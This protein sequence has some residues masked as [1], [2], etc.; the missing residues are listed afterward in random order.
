MERWHE[1]QVIVKMSHAGYEPACVNYYYCRIM[2]LLGYYHCYQIFIEFY[3]QI[4]MTYLLNCKLV[5][6]RWQ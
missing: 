4:D 6:T 1:V 3:Y 5:A 2:L